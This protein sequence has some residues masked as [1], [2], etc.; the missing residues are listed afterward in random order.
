MD[1]NKAGGELNAFVTPRKWTPRQPLVIGLTVIVSAVALMG[2]RQ[3]GMR[4]AIAFESDQSEFDFQGDAQLQ[5]R[6][7][8]LMAD[9]CNAKDPLDVALADFGNSPFAMREAIVP[10]QQAVNTAPL[11]GESPEAAAARVAAAR[12][13]ALLNEAGKL[14]LHSVMGGKRPLARIDD[15]T[16]TV[17]DTVAEYF[18]VTEI[19]GRSVTITADGE[20]FTLTMQAG[21]MPPAGGSGK[22]RP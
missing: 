5:T 8:R 17:G 16:V 19:S 20:S 12:K 21:N 4:S 1:S 10:L 13:T 15:E 6:Y 2:M 7:E 14:V 22:R 9:L 18:T 11:A 3:I